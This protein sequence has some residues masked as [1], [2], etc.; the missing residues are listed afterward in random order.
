[1]KFTFFTIFTFSKRVLTTCSPHVQ[2]N[3]G[4]LEELFWM[5]LITNG[6]I[7]R[8]IVLASGGGKNHI[9]PYNNL[10]EEPPSIMYAVYFQP[11]IFDT[12]RNFWLKLSFEFS[13]SNPQMTFKCSCIV[14][15]PPSDKTDQNLSKKWKF[16]T[17]EARIFEYDRNF[18]CG[19]KLESSIYDPQMSLAFL[20][21]N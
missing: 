4:G 6:L 8:P 18:C 20:H 2:S 21:H 11:R 1:M 3:I 9:F 7:I 10:M 14:S 5:L 12:V 13:T 15:W 19:W 16:C 17:F